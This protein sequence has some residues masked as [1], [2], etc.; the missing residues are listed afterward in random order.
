MIRGTLADITAKVREAKITL[1]ALILVGP[2]LD[3]ALRLG[4]PLKEDPATSHLYSEDYT[5]RYRRS[6][7]KAGRPAAKGFDRCKEWPMT[8]TAIVAISRNGSTLAKRL[9]ACMS[10]DTTLYLER[11]FHQQADPGVVFDLPVRPVVQKLFVEQQRLVLF[12]PV[13]AAVRLLAPCLLDKHADP[14]VVCVDDAGRF[15]VSL[16]SGHLGGADRLAQEVANA[17]GATPVVTSAA[18]VLDTLAIDQLGQE[19]GWQ[20]EAKSGAVTRASA[21]VVNGEPV[22]LFNQAGEP[23]WWPPGQLMP[24]NVTRYGSLESLKD[25]SWSAALIISDQH[26]PWADGV[27]Q[28]DTLVVVYRPRNL[29]VGM[30]CRRGV[31]MAELDDLLV[32]TFLCHNLAVGSLRCIATAE[33]KQEEPGLIQLAAKYGVPLL[34]Y[35][36]GEL[37]SV[38]DSQ[39]LPESQ[40]REGNRPKRSLAND[41]D[42][43]TSRK[44]PE[45]MPSATVE[46]VSEPTPRPRVRQL[47]GM[48]GVS[49]PAAL[50]A[51]ESE[52]LLVPRIKTQRTTIAVAR[53]ELAKSTG[54]A[55]TEST[56]P[57][58]APA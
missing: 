58:D 37:N 3:P 11:R 14:A 13:G 16:L 28:P 29:I 53:M 18:H 22:G 38:F 10:E 48:W 17:L 44:P 5:H 36:A 56:G 23:G 57:G 35:T 8:G 46:D 40:P 1:Q 42:E 9:A 15:A 26:S 20:I 4:D 27:F 39:S 45:G 49:E 50:L 33:L 31:P 24:P 2:A 34:C 21:A 32:N 55:A 54:Q 47:L 43:G 7:T 19:F 12:M 41:G 52:K 25:A 30:G 6:R 51:A